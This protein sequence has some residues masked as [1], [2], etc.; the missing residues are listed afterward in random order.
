MEIRELRDKERIEAFLRSNCELHIYSIGDLDEFFWPHTRW[1]AWEAGGQVK[2]V[3]LVYTG[4]ALPTVIGLSEQP[5][6][7]G[8]LL[9]KVRSQLPKHFHAHLSPGVEAVF[10][11]DYAIEAHGAHYRMAL[12]DASRLR[13]IDCSKV[14]PLTEADLNEV[15]DFY[16]TS[17]PNN[18]FDER[19]LKT[20]QYFGLRKK[21]RLA[22]VAGVHV[23]SRR[24]RVAALGNIATDPA[25]R[26][27]GYGRLVTGRLCQALAG[28]VDHVGLNVRV[29]NEAAIR[30]YRSLGFETVAPYGEFNIKALR[31]GRRE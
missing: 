14:E 17:Y 30:C 11:N 6:V 1:L 25:H 19:M 15:L 5:D 16:A 24:Y 10:R 4:K 20:G 18:W 12:R 27:R 23:Y 8:E 29:D 9:E 31:H 3:V 28:H 7:M 26:N 13:E 22:S 2:D 21:G